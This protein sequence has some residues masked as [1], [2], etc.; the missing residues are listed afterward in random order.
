M[1]KWLSISLF[2]LWLGLPSVA[3][4]ATQITVYTAAAAEEVNRIDRAFAAVNKEIALTWV[5]DSTDRILARLRAEQRQPK[6]DVVWM[7]AASGLAGLAAEDYFH[8]YAPKGFD[9]LQRSLSDRADPPRWIGQRAWAN[10]LCVNPG[11]LE[12]ESL[13]APTRWG[14]LLDPALRGKI[15]ALDPAASRTGLSLLAGWFALWGDAGAWRYMEG[16]HRNVAAYFRAGATP[17]D[18]VAR[19][20]YPVGISYAYRA[21]KLKGKGKPIA[22]VLPGDGVGWDVEATAIVKGTP[23]LD[24][25]RAFVD[26]TVGT[27]AMALQSRGFGLVAHPAVQPKRRFYPEGMAKALVPL[28]FDNIAARR[29]RAIAEWRLRFGAKSEPGG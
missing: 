6:A 21:A 24:A 12:A 4:G 5:R 25:A 10:A 27:A 11:L 7:V 8:A 13:K 28:N 16:L 22:L 14:D 23:Y 19:G 2:G 3:L 26:W 29:E 20:K 18:L 1:R 15:A 17:C 9:R